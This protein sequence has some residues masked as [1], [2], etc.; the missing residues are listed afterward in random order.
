MSTAAPGTINPLDGSALSPVQ[1]TPAKD[2][3]DLVDASRQ[4]Q[5]GWAAQSLSARSK[6]VLAFARAALD[7]HEEIIAILAQETGRSGMECGLNEANG[8]LEYA[9]GAVKVAKSALKPI[10]VGLNPVVFPGKK[11]VIESLP[12]GVVGIIAPW[13]YPLANFYK[14]LFPA[15]LSG[16]GVV[17]KPSEHTP[18]SGAWLA[19]VAAETLPAGLVQ[20]AQGDGVVG[21]AVV[22]AVDA[23]VFTGSVATGRRIAARAGERLIPASVELG[24]KDAAIVLA[25]CDL[26][27][28]VAGIVQWS[29]HNAG[30][31]CAAIERVFVEQAIAEAF[32]AAMT[33]A[34]GR[35]RVEDG[36]G[37]SELGP[38]Q[39]A[40]QLAIVEDHVADAVAKGATLLCG[41]KRIGPG[42]GYAPTLLDHCTLG[43]KVVD[44]ETFGPVVAVLRVPDAKSAVDQA[45][46]SRFGLNGSVWT[47]DIARGEQLARRLE[48]GV[49]NV[50]NH[51]FAGIVP[52]I[53]WTG[54]KET[55]HGVAASRF[56]YGTF[57]RPRTLLVDRN[58]QPDPFWMPADKNLTTLAVAVRDLSRGTLTAVFR[59]LPI[60]GK[61]TRAIRALSDE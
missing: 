17:M 27:R 35:L 15:L 52:Q 30:Q 33:R 54:V 29:M 28:T 51:S 34:V 23:V 37:E 3:A 21:A 18:R 26:A 22:D 45:N 50:N 47:R 19:G 20:L 14:S 39:N 12:R 10:K 48:V 24:G 1:A 43:M 53:P 61:R 60:L 7:R 57:T 8:I 46:A 16:N 13:N 6:A 44:E 58:K 42:L 5:I 55:G 9:R 38:L 40:Q 25:D 2:V 4:A 11:A 41:G 56:S 59:L 32:I 36:S 31:N 49:A